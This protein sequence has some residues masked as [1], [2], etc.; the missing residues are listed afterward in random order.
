M[1]STLTLQ[2]KRSGSVSSSDVGA[3]PRKR[4]NNSS[5]SSAGVSPVTKPHSMPWLS[6]NVSTT[7]RPCATDVAKINTARRSA[8]SSTISA[9]AADTR[10]S[11]P[12]RR[13][14]F[15]ADELA[16]THVNARKV[17][18]VDA[19]FGNQRAQV[20]VADQFLDADLVTDCDS[21]NDPANRSCRN[22]VG[23]ASRSIR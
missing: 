16:G 12:A 17:G 23:T 9:H 20:T 8:V 14:D 3:S 22:R 7:R 13:F 21:G 10:A 19:G 18:S 11:S 6:R 4:A 1:V 2:R 5:R 15:F